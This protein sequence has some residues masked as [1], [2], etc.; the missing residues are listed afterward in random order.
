MTTEVSKYGSTPPS[1]RKPSGKELWRERRRH[2][3]DIRRPHAETDEREHVGAAIPKRRPGALEERAARPQHHR[4]RK[5]EL[6]Q[7]RDVPRNGLDQPVPEQHLAHGQSEHR[8]AERRTDP[9]TDASC[10]SARGWT[11][12][13]GSRPAARAPSR[14]S[15]SSRQCPARRRDAWDRCIR[16]SSASR[17]GGPARAPSRRSDRAPPRSPALPDTWDRHR[18][19]PVGARRP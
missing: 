5:D 18:W 3:V 17:P 12:P 4:C 11:A 1:I 8:E 10:R 7:I 19:C 14:T 16:P 13:P 15:G 2:A 9:E 6:D